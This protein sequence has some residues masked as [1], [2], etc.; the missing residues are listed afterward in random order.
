[1]AEGEEEKPKLLH[2]SNYTLES[3]HAGAGIGNN[4]PS[5]IRQTIK[6]GTN[7]P[8][9]LKRTGLLSVKGGIPEGNRRSSLQ[10]IPLTQKAN[11]PAFNVRRVTGTHQRMHNHLVDTPTFPSSGTDP[12]PQDKELRRTLDIF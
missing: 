4:F 3:N 5:F 6:K 12:P 7:M 11:I 9:L 10:S 8:V 2:C 1:M